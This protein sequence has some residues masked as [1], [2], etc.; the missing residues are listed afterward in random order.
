MAQLLFWPDSPDRSIA[1][2]WR[3]LEAYLDAHAPAVLSSLN[4]PA[5]D[6]QLAQAEA[7][8]GVSFPDD[9]KESLRVCNGQ[10]DSF[11]I[12]PAE[13]DPKRGTTI[14][15]WGELLPLERIVYDTLAER[16]QNKNS[17]EWA[18]GLEYDGPVRRDGNWS[19]LC[20]VDPGSGDRIWLDLDPADGGRVGQVLSMCHDPPRLFVIA[21]SYREWFEQLVNRYKSGRYYFTEW[22]RGRLSAVDGWDTREGR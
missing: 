3:R 7:Q 20:I 11:H 22:G 17:Q 14:A 16:E 10:T 1:G 21:T 6:E 4:P 13:F 15:T 8:L 5:T 18:Y 2:L 9:L 12:V 19:C